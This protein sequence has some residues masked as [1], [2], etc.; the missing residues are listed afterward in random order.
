MDMTDQEETV[1][2]DT[3]LLQYLSK[4]LHTHA[5]KFSI[6]GEIVFSCCKVLS[7]QDSYIKDK[8]FLIFLLKA[9]PQ[10]APCLKSIHQKDIYCVVPDQNAIYVVGP[11]SFASSVYLICHVHI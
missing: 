3:I 6:D 1:M 5:Y 9:L 11:V 8:D 4:K 10:K 2:Q 7:F